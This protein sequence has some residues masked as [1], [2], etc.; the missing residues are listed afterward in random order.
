MCGEYC[1]EALEK[2]E[3]PDKKR[4]ELKGNVLNLKDP[5]SYQDGFVTSHPA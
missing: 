4:E 1:R 5:V 2:T 3:K